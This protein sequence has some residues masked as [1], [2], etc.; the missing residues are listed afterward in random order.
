MFQFE[1]VLAKL[2]HDIL[3]KV[4]ILAKENK[5]N[6]EELKKIPYEIINGDIPK[7]RDN[8]NH[9]REVVLQRAKL[10]AGYLP[11]GIEAKELVDISKDK[12][13][14]YV[15]KEAC[16]RCPTKK[17]EVTDA[18]RNCIAHKCQSVCRFDAISYINGR[19][20]IDPEKCR[21]CGM[22]KSVCPY[23]AIA[24]DMRPCKRACITGAL[25]YN[26]EDLSSE[27]DSQKCINCGEC[28]AACPFGA[29]EDRSQMVNVIYELEGS[30][31]VFAIVA[32]AIEGQFKPS[33]KYGQV[34]N[35]IINIGFKDMVEVAFGADAVTV[36]ESNELK[37]RMENGDSY[38]TSS[39]CP[40]FVNYIE[41]FFP[42]E[43]KKIST[44]VSPMVATGRYIKSQ[45]KDSIVV[46]VG[47]CT[48]KKN[49][50]LRDSVSD[51]IDY[52]LTFE[53]L[54]AM[55]DAY[56]IN[57][58]KCNDEFED[59]ASVFGR[60]FGSSGGLTNAIT[61]YIK[62]S[63]INLDFKPVKASGSIEI[64]KTMAVAKLKKV[65]GNFIEGMMC[66]GGCINGPSKIVNAKKSKN[67][68]DKIN[69]QSKIK[70]ISDEKLKE[71]LNIK[72]E[73]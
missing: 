72:M 10:A 54:F 49:E 70:N 60:G 67:T 29:L 15:I 11:N 4:A 57:V 20:H 55:F 9:E 41:K 40:A 7:Y 42:S 28:M 63:N 64:K 16:D 65:N 73:R 31:D 23:D 2:K 59:K 43:I 52:V 34:R 24:E 12:Q 5:V 6:L 53:E 45:F 1:N 46:F 44:T 35:A 33:I 71:Y 18:C 3:T 61:N 26:T 27:L 47:P 62:N 21:E 58:E 36:H 69:N 30:K 51:A 17:F 19:A 22:C 8:T 39:C 25:S 32:P 38:M 14:L 50:A 68:F 66:E 56:N 37:E 13:I 48:A